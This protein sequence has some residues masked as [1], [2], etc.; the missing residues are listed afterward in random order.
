[1]KRV[2]MAATALATACTWV[3]L[4]EAGQGVRVVRQADVGDCEKVGTARVNTRDT[5]GIFAR[6]SRRV[7]QELQNLARNDA[8]SELDGDTIVAR[9]P[10]EKGGRQVFDV[11]RCR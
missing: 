6:S 3:P 9:G 10:V 2:W 4:N 1:M 8:A 7:A 5:V 11:Y